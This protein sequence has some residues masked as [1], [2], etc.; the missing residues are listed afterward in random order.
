M[1]QAGSEDEEEDGEDDG[2]EDPEGDSDSESATLKF[3]ISH[4]TFANRKV[5]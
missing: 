3:S 4:S 1:D 5:T 2:E